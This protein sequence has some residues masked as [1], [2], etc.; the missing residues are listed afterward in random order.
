M[1]NSPVKS[2]DPDEY[3]VVSRSPGARRLQ[4]KQADD[5]WHSLQRRIAHRF[6]EELPR[7]S[8]R[9]G[10][11]LKWRTFAERTLPHVSPGFTPPCKPGPIFL[12]W[13]DWSGVVVYQIPQQEFQF[14]LALYRDDVFATQATV[15]WL[16]Y[17]LGDSEVPHSFFVDFSNL[18]H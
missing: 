5:V 8:K 7:K 13:L 6:R 4:V 10:T 11:G 12:G 15:P 1:D 3:L 18:E 14:D 17:H 16:L 9:D 2:W